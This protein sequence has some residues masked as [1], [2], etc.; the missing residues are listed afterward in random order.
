GADVQPARLGR[1]GWRESQG[2]LVR[3]G[4]RRPE[5]SDHSV[6]SRTR[7]VE[8]PASEPPCCARSGREN[9]GAPDEK[10]RKGATATSYPGGIAMVRVWFACAAPLVAG[11]ATAFSAQATPPRLPLAL[12]EGQPGQT[13]NLDS[14]SYE[15]QS[16]RLRW[17]MVSATIFRNGE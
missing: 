1:T 3:R 9:R 2:L 5:R 12:I 14:V 8:A 15:I 17:V 11:L 13:G 10:R 4:R 16:D 7:R 6:A